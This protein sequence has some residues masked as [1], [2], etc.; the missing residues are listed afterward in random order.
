MEFLV[1]GESAFDDLWKVSRELIGKSAFLS[2]VTFERLLQISPVFSES[3][4]QRYLFATIF[5]VGV[6]VDRVRFAVWITS[7]G[8]IQHAKNKGPYPLFIFHGF[9][10]AETERSQP[11]R[12]F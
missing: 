7:F 5:T 8:Y 11:L 3:D 12:S 2:N 9:M 1:G 4:P 10:N 6:D